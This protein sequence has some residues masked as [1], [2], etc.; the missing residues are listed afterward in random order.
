MTEVEILADVIVC[1]LCGA[2]IH[3]AYSAWY[4]HFINTHG[5]NPATF[6]GP[7]GP[8]K[9]TYKDSQTGENGKR[10]SP[11]FCYLCGCDCADN[12]DLKAHL[13]NAHGAS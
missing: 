9:G 6:V 3:C 7:C 4:G 13:Q 10:R 8:H 1:P 2:E 11:F 5:A 12:D